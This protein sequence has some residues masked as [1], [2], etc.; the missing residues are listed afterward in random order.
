MGQGIGEVFNDTCSRLIE[1]SYRSIYVLDYY[2]NRTR[3]SITTPCVFHIDFNIEGFVENTQED[4][5]NYFKSMDLDLFI[6]SLVNLARKSLECYKFNEFVTKFSSKIL[7]IES[8]LIKLG[9]LV[10]STE[11][12]FH[13]YAISGDCS[14]EK[15]DRLSSFLPKEILLF[16]SNLNIQD[17]HQQKELKEEDN[18]VRKNQSNSSS[19]GLYFDSAGNTMQCGSHGREYKIVDNVLPTRLV[20]I[21]EGRLRHMHPSDVGSVSFFIPFEPDRISSPRSSIEQVILHALAP[22]VLGDLTT[23]I[24]NGYLGA[25]YWVQSRASDN[26]KE[27]HL[28]TAITWC[29]D[30]GWPTEAS[31]ACHAI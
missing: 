19:Q 27:F 24:Q 30:H 20:D 4:V 5:G 17:L 1:T 18:D 10:L 28:D 7:E 12:P 9:Y 3:S 8:K 26:P 11:I 14:N 6:R 16:L 22:A 13:I 29:R 25:E 21:L 15:Y 23:A 31:A 2:S